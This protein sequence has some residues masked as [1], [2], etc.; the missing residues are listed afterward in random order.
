[1]VLMLAFAPASEQALAFGSDEPDFHNP[2]L[3]TL[4]EDEKPDKSE[5][6]VDQSLSTGTKS[7]T[8]TGDELANLRVYLHDLRAPSIGLTTASIKYV[9]QVNNPNRRTVKGPALVYEAF[10]GDVSVAIGRTVVPDIPGGSHRRY[11]SGFIVSYIDL[12]RSLVEAVRNRDFSL[13]IDGTV[14]SEGEHARFATT[15]QVVREE[16]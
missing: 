13:R 14:S 16:F 1:M 6:K 10:I 12:G 7:T 5:P 3:E 15:L 8:I 11:E 4:N 2:F 9:I